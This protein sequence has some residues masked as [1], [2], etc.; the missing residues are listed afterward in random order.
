MHEFNG[1]SALSSFR[2]Q[3]LLNRLQQAH[4]TTIADVEARHVYFLESDQDLS[5]RDRQL[6]ATLLEADHVEAG[7]WPDHPKDAA[8][9]DLQLASSTAARESNLFLV[10]PRQGTISP[11]S[12]KATDIL[13]N[14]GLHSIARVERGTAYAVI[15]ENKLKG[16][17]RKQIA[18]LL[19]D[20]MTE[21]VFHEFAAASLLFTHRSPGTMDTVD[22]L[23]GGSGALE[24]ANVELGLALA[25]D[26]IEY[27]V[28]AFEGLQRNPTDVELMMFAQANSEHCRHKIFN[29]SWIVDDEACPHSLFGMIR[30]TY[31]SAP[32]GILSA[33]S[34]NAAVIQGSTGERF[35]ADPATG[36][37]KAVVEPA[38][39]LMKV[40]THNHPTAISP[41]PGAATGSGGEIRDEGATGRG[42]KPKAGLAGFTVSNLFIPGAVQPWE[43]SPGRPERFAS[44]LEIMID[45]PIGAAAF[46]NEFG[47]P[48]LCGYFR[49]YEMQA[50][51]VNGLE[52]RGYHKPIM[53]AG[54][55]GTIRE[56]HVQK[57]EVPAGSR[58]V[59]LGGPAMLIGL[60][61]GAASSVGGGASSE[62]LD[63]ASVQR[64]NP[65]MERRCQEVIDRCWELGSSNPILFIHD[66]GAGGLSNAL[67]ELV[68]DAGRGGQF[69]IRDIPSDEPGMSPM[70]I[71]SNESQERYVLAIAEA[72]VERFDQI[73][74]RER[75]PYAIVGTA[76]DEKHIT[77]NDQYFADKPVDLPMQVLFGK[78]PRME[79]SFNRTGF[80][81]ATFDSTRID[82]NEAVDRV[83]S[84]P[85]VASKKFLITIGDR[86][87]SGQVCRDQ[88]V[89]PWQ[90]PVADCA[91][92]MTG[93]TGFH[94]EAMAMGERT[95]VATIDAAASARMAVGEVITNIAAARIRHLSDIRLSANW[96]S[97][98]AHPGENEALYDAVH[99]VGMALC[100]ELGIAIPVGK[101]SMSMSTRWKVDGERAF[102]NQSSG[103]QQE[104]SVISPM[105]L[106]VSGFA[107]VHDVRRSLTPQL[108][109]IAD[110]TL[111][112]IDLGF[113]RNRVGG[114]ALTQVFKAT[115][116]IAPDLDSPSTLA[117]F[118]EVIQ[119][120]N[121]G[122]YLRAYHDR[123]D[124][125]LFTT[126]AEMAFAGRCGVNIQLDR[127]VK[128]R[129]HI[130][131]ELF[132]EELGA[133]LQVESRHVQY[134]HSMFV[135]NGLEEA[136]LEIGEVVPESDQLIFRFADD[137]IVQRSRASLERLWAR[138]SYEIQRLRDNPEC[139]DEEFAIIESNDDIGLRSEPSFDMSEVEA[140][141]A[142]VKRSGLSGVTGGQ[143]RRRIAVL[144]EQGVNGQ[145]EMAA[146]FASMGL[147]SVDVHM[148]DILSGRVSLKDFEALVAC[149]GFSYG[150]VLGAGSGWANTIL[151]NP[152]A[153]DEFQAFFERPDTLA[154]GVCNGCQMFAQIKSLI[155]GADHW[156]RFLRNRS[157]Q[158]EAR[159]VMVE[160]CR[161]PSI[162]LDGMAGSILPVAVAHGEG[163]ADLTDKQAAELQNH[164]LVALRYVDSTGKPASSYPSNPGGSTRGV[165]GMTTADGRV[166]IMMPHPERVFR[167]IQHSWSPRAN[168]GG[169]SDRTARLSEFSPWAKM[170]LNAAKH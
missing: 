11:W 150:D 152:R 167:E 6:A 17:V 132:N 63:F 131:R 41:F 19:H 102:E 52:W 35:F 139:A 101:D 48:N 70:E 117:W 134:V 22:I 123:S 16:K 62:G 76:T 55:L 142:I 7:Q 151:H 99:A 81:K 33:Y 32:D 84:L 127:W 140:Q 104:V 108:L 161:S 100:P 95:P 65:E 18:A 124:G 159:L 137:V 160:V 21:S 57:G 107:P 31:N 162:L 38:H 79:R 9:R 133:V 71:W 83:L 34:D 110:T 120:L 169:R 130:V 1:S 165:T 119:H 36:S 116:A 157:E 168:N 163:R 115:G 40:E 54:G 30:N 28:A 39:I 111:I 26:E 61:G 3:R 46:N 138:T 73:C 122:D 50:A 126:L 106:I 67:P 129:S 136:Y 135:Q 37:Y 114:S 24:K 60:G 13:H 112:L 148:T 89:G 94:G 23:G 4:G 80:T 68:K 74:A 25:P 20:R 105:S 153:K 154:L 166:T 86:T 158:F 147:D 82:V 56:E 75:C 170:F 144:R 69:E 85:A 12:S 58:L 47:R 91:V 78:P 128:E 5:A 42:A 59:V 164:Q 143:G 43:E 93:F 92:T 27:L 121:D 87:I 146:A 98:A 45:G 53:L 14:C 10:L 156:P 109:P 2:K 51:T 113:G 90:V 103:M 49:T 155:P 141:A 8:P 88:M 97:A 44:P 145:L 96:M 77:L 15:S 29:A 149:G 118:F 64:G 125:G 72:S 66:V